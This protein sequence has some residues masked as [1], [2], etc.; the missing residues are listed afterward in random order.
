MY[1]ARKESETTRRWFD[2][3]HVSNIGVFDRSLKSEV[4]GLKILIMQAS[5]LLVTSDLV[6]RTSDLWLPTS[7]FGLP[8]SALAPNSHHLLLS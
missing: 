2:E 8:T 6:L 1:P 4:R 5:K 7:D 3:D